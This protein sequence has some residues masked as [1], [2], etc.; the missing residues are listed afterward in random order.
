MFAR[1]PAAQGLTA[2]AL[3]VSGCQPCPP[4][5]DLVVTDDQGRSAASLSQAQRALDDFLRWSQAD[6]LCAR[7]LRFASAE[8]RER[9]LEKRPGEGGVR[10][11]ILLGDGDPYEETLHAVCHAYDDRVEGISNEHRAAFEGLLDSDQLQHGRWLERHETF[12]TFCAEGPQGRALTSA[13]EQCGGP[14]QEAHLQLIWEE[15]YQRFPGRPPVYA[16]SDLWASVGTTTQPLG[17]AA[18]VRLGHVGDALL[19]VRVATD[20]IQIGGPLRAGVFVHGPGWEVQAPWSEVDPACALLSGV[21]RGLLVCE[22]E[23]DRGAW[24]IDDQGSLTAG[25][26]DLPVPVTGFVGDEQT[27]LLLPTNELVALDP[28]GTRAPLGSLDELELLHVADITQIDGETVLLAETTQAG[29]REWTLDALLAGEPGLALPTGGAAVWGGVAGLG[30]GR[31]YLLRH[32]AGDDLLALGEAGSGP[33]LFDTAGCVGRI[34]LL[35]GGEAIREVRLDSG[36]QGWIA[37]VT[38][39]ERRRDT[40]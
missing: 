6:S 13:L 4:A 12:A 24:W 15:V 20:P 9:D 1:E 40:P 32:F 23:R 34:D 35:L 19:F 30:D 21:S 37:S 2:A 11:P 3:C 27:L 39:R 33:R 10:R 16:T 8:E 7:E 28:A 31:L 29:S 26:T 36:E 17:P 14:A 5:S 38:T 25:P 18:G 22:S